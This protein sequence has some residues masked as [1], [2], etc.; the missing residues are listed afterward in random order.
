MSG[1]H[2]STSRR[3]RS[4]SAIIADGLTPTH[5][6]T[7]TSSASTPQPRHNTRPSSFFGREGPSLFRLPSF[8]EL[9]AQRPRSIDLST[10]QPH[11][12]TST[13]TMAT[14]DTSRLEIIDL[15][16]E[17]DTDV[18][19]PVEPD[20]RHPA[21]HPY[22]RATRG[23]RFPAEII[24]LSGD[25]PQRPWHAPPQQQE[26]NNDDAAQNGSPEIQFLRARQLS[27][28][29][30]FA[31]ATPPAGRIPNRL[32][33]QGRV[34]P[35][36][37][38]DDDEVQIIGERQITPP[39]F[40]HPPRRIA[41]FFSSFGAAA[42]V[43]ADAGLIAPRDVR[44]RGSHRGPRRR[45]PVPPHRDFM[46][47]VPNLDFGAAAFDLGYG[48][49]PEPGAEREQ[50]VVPPPE[51]AP[52]GFTRNPTEE[53][54]LICPNCDAELSVGDDDVKRQVW[55]VKSCGHVSWTLCHSWRAMKTDSWIDLLWR[56]RG[57]SCC[58][59]A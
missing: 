57:K 50:S 19:R 11:N 2:Q 35:I 7:S 34:A 37:I 58:A 14:A 44:A 51:P 54:V 27:P 16:G 47:E 17:P 3:T 59:A 45:V 41:N 15:T 55:L 21:W 1:R 32:N 39:P 5:S 13:S 29:L 28:R 24:D 22:G 30:R 46:F 23:P 4:P 6:T 38:N 52:E 53:D 40:P 48:I 18:P 9:E 33:P 42:R 10:S 31:G 49:E 25:T 8:Q 36:E 12:P 43:L 20:W 26:G 56:V